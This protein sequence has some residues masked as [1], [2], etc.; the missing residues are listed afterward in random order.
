MCTCIFREKQYC[1]VHRRYNIIYEFYCR[2]LIPIY[3]PA[4]RERYLHIVRIS[5]NNSFLKFR[6]ES[7]ETLC[8][9]FFFP[10]PPYARINASDPTYTTEFS[11][12][13]AREK[14]ARTHSFNGRNRRKMLFFAKRF[15]RTADMSQINL[16]RRCLTHTVKMNHRVTSLWH[17]REA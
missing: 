4:R 16:E 11:E 12:I 6:W 15:H 9:F 17:V 5:R 10:S 2:L 13:V 14:V 7:W 8:F 1:S 3:M